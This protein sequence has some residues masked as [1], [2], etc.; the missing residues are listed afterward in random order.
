MLDEE[1]EDEAAVDAATE[2]EVEVVVVVVEVRGLFEAAESPDTD[3]DAIMSS[4]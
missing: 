3:E 4:N 2:V 1:L